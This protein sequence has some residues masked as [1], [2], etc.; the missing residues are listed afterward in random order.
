MPRGIT[1]GPV[2]PRLI[3]IVAVVACCLA[4]PDRVSAFHQQGVGHCNSCHTMHNL[5]DGQLVDPDHPDG[6][7]DLLIDAA[8]S[9]VCLSCHSEQLG[10][11]FG[12]DPLIP[13]PE[14]G[15]GNFVF[16]LEDNLND[17]PDGAINPIDGSAA[18]HSIDA[19]S[20]GVAPDG[21]HPQ[22]PGGGFPSHRLGC[23]SCHD[24]HGNTNFRMLRG[25]GP[26]GEGLPPFRRP[27]PEAVGIELIGAIESDG[28]HSAY[29]YGV[30]AWCA[31]CHTRYGRDHGEDG[32][33]EH[34][35]DE[36]LNR[37]TI[38]NYHRY[39]GTAD[40]FGGN[41]ATAY[42]AAVPFEDP[43]VTV[44][45]TAGPGAASSVMCLSC[46]RA[47]ATSAPQAGRWDFNVEFLDTDG[48][49]SGSYPIPNPYLDPAQESLCQK[50]HGIGVP[51]YSDHPSVHSD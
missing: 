12:F 15:G 9:D 31:N 44:S 27:A 20:R 29:N 40:P 6:N 13:P 4:P 47:H 24:P 8:A 16:L 1:H 5:Q 35:V 33:F 49:V 30:S 36:N 38:R 7:D 3:G 32:G 17:A 51:D 18:G 25:A 37:R 22:A 48:A 11:V 43:A 39:N 2:T 14:L 23:T 45:S 28:Y 46:H 21:T 34:P 50:C 41:A 42:L 19:P 26:V 10:A